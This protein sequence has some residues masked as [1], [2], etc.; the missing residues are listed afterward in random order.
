[1]AGEGLAELDTH[2]SNGST[3][4]IAACTETLCSYSAMSWPSADGVISLARIVV[5]RLPGRGTV[6]DLL[7]RD[8]VG[9]DLRR[10]P[11]EG[12]GLGL[13]EQVGD[14]QVL[15]FAEVV[16]RARDADQVDRHEL[17]P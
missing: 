9:L 10:R 2:W 3:S 12:Q 17:R 5:G 15:V 7:G 13:S 8:A 11:A 14:Q 16:A 4:Q 6:G 1:M